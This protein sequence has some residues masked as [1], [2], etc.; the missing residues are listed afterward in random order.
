MRKVK[1]QDIV[2]ELEIRFANQEVFYNKK[3]G[4]FLCVN[5][6]EFRIT[7]KDD[8]KHNLENYAKWQR[9]HLEDVYKLEYEEFDDYI[10]LPG[11][12][13]I[14]DSDI[15]EEFIDSI[16]DNRKR[17]ELE[18]CMWQKGMYRKF[19]DKI[20]QLGLE[21]QY[22]RFYDEKLNELAKKWCNKNNLEYE[23]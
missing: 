16:K 7:E 23:E 13:D 22:F 10:K 20:I 4:E 12:F 8:F 17:R 2:D 11:S 1:L 6:D 21:S 3:T 14:R 18:N 5:E 19:K 9:E 15:M